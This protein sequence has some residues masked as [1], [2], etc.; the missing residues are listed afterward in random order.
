MLRITPTDSGNRNIT[1]RLE[2]R[3]VGPWVTELCKACDK[4]MGEGLRL[5]LNLA[6]VSFLEPAGVALVSSLRSKGVLLRQCSSFVEAQLES[7]K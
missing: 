5:E 6:E 3:I 2:G 7:S 1:L 4:I